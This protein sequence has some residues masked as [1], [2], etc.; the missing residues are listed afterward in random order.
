MKMSLFLIPFLFSVQSF[1][2]DMNLV[3]DNADGAD[4]VVE[5][6]SFEND[7]AKV[8]FELPTKDKAEFFDV[9]AVRKN[10]PEQTKYEISIQSLSSSFPIKMTVGTFDLI[11]V[12]DVTCLVR[13]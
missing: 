8:S 7:V 11:S 1:A 9:T 12:G 3:C 13:D 4:T 10:G 6:D 5:S 2:G